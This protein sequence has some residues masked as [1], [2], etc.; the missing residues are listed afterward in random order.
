MTDMSLDDLDGGVLVHDW[1]EPVGG[2]ENVLEELAALMP[3]A[4]LVCAWMNAPQRF[5]GRRIVETALARP[6]WRDHKARALLASTVLWRG[7]PDAGYRWAL[8]SSHSF[9]HHCRFRHQA[10][11]F[12]KLVYVHSPARYLWNPELDGR[13]NGLAARL[14]AGPLR[15]LDRRRAAEPAAL[16]ANSG[17]VR[18]RIRAHW[19]RD[20]TVIHPPVAVRQIRDRVAE[21]E[22]THQDREV[23]DGLPETFLLGASR[24]ISYKR[25][26]LVIT[27]AGALGWPAVIAGGGPQ[28]AALRQLAAASGVEVQFVGVVSTP[29]LR[30]LYARAHVYLFPSVEDF[31]I[32]PVE[33]MAAGCPVVAPAVGGTAES[34]T[35]GLS[36]HLVR[37]WDEPRTVVDAV[38]RAAGLDRAA[39]REAADVFAA[40]RFATRIEEWVRDHVA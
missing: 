35:D 25:L 6:P 14:A 4:D 32:M 1:V 11:D 3:G 28:E 22:L 19:H 21:S 16:A 23:L 2:S 27:T 30:A 18:D 40:E 20:A 5:P 10:D 38:R 33:A 24:L 9:A 12:V 17:Y 34:V 39:V 7:V 15:G 13:G 8:V 31:G 26:D 29:L 36:G 37:K